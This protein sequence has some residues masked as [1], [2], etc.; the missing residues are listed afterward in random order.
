MQLLKY[1]SSPIRAAKDKVLIGA[2]VGTCTYD[3][4]SAVGDGLMTWLGE[5]MKLLETICSVLYHDMYLYSYM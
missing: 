4:G 3:V 5:G 1:A 2:G